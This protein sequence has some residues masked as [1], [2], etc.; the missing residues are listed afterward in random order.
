[1]A[2]EIRYNYYTEGNTVRKETV[3]PEQLISEG[4]VV[5]KEAVRPEPQWDPR[6]EQTVR[7]ESRA[8][9]KNR[10]RALSISLPYGIMLLAAT[11]VIVFA[12][13]NYLRVTA[14]IN[15]SMKHIAAMEAE[16]SE[17]KNANNTLQD[18][19]VAAIDLGEVY[20]IATARLGMVYP[21]ENERLTYTAH[22][23]EYV[24]QYENVPTD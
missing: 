22:E 11:A 15:A 4:N 3:Y 14:Q 24:S 2:E 9:R 8:V 18:R 5:R 20:E 23:R 6:E 12:C 7:H 1:M 10:E 19:I 13:V 16:L 21:D 17:L